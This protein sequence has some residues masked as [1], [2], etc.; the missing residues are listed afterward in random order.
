MRTRLGPGE[1]E[2]TKELAGPSVVWAMEGKGLL[3]A[4]GREWSVKEGYIFF[5]V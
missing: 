1:D 5:V 4:E 2:M 3:K